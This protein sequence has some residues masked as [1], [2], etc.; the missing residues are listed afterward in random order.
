MYVISIKCEGKKSIE[1]L[2]TESIQQQTEW[3]KALEK[4]RIL[5]E[6]ERKRLNAPI[7]YRNLLGISQDEKL[8]QNVITRAYRK[9]CLKV[10][11]Y[12]I[13]LIHYLFIYIFI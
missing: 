6:E 7:Q 4:S 10:Y 12:I 5:H 11:I 9:L 2:I 13:I 1:Y 3:Y 8:T